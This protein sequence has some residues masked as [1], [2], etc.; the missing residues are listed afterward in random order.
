MTLVTAGRVGRAHGLDGSFWVDDAR[1]ELAEGTRLVIGTTE[2]VVARRGGTDERPLLRLAD[3]EDSR[4][5]RGE[6]LMV[7]DVLGDDEWLAAD[8]VGLEVGDLGRVQRVLDGPS[9]S[10]LELDDGTLVPFVS[11]AIAAVGA[12]RIEL[13]KDFLG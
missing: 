2:H 12:R 6:L 4:A 8:L 7:E 13:R 5:L 1:H 10:L 3:V 9:C 11:D